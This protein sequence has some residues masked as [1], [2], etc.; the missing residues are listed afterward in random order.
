LRLPL[1]FIY[2]LLKRNAEHEKKRANIYSISTAR[3]TSVVLA[4]ANGFSGNKSE[5]K[6]KI[7]ELLPFPLD[8]KRHEKDEETIAIYRQLI[9]DG[10]I[11]LYVIAALNR[12]I[13]I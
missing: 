8:E 3:L 12:V 13:D 11:P 2:E 9:K 10:K 4:V 7:D 1:G 6:V 5:C